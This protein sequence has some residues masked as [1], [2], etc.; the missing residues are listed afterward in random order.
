MTSNKLAFK[1]EHNPR[2]VNVWIEKARDGR[3]TPILDVEVRDV[4]C[5]VNHTVRFCLFVLKFNKAVINF[6][7]KLE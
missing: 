1:C 3:I 5:G 6:S 7:V 4:V 2:K